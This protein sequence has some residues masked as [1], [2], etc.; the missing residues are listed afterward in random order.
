ML[1]K[2]LD[3]TLQSFFNREKQEEDQVEED[4]R[5]SVMVTTILQ[6][7]RSMLQSSSTH[8]T[9]YEFIELIDIPKIRYN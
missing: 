4:E 1:L 7:L 6:K 9:V 8:Y 2:R 3:V 5:E